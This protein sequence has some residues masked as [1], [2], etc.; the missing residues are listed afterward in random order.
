MCIDTEGSF[1]CACHE[2]YALAADLRS[3]EAIALDKLASRADG[4]LSRKLTESF[5]IMSFILC[6]I[7]A[8][9]VIFTSLRRRTATGHLNSN[10]RNSAGVYA[11][12]E[13]GIDAAKEVTNK[14]GSINSKLSMVSSMS[15]HH[16]TDVLHEYTNH[17]QE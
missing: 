2:D 8:C 13:S 4:F 16:D 10:L 6:L 7:I 17:A 3:C 12:G 9:V 11:G 15:S 1:T 5:S 14:F